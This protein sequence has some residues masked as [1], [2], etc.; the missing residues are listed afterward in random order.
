[1]DEEGA[2]RICKYILKDVYESNSLALV[3]EIVILSED[4]AEFMYNRKLATHSYCCDVVAIAGS[5]KQGLQYVIEILYQVG[6]DSNIV[7]TFPKL[8]ENVKVHWQDVK[9]MHGIMKLILQVMERC[10]VET[11]D[12]IVKKKI[13]S[14]ISVMSSLLFSTIPFSMELNIK[15]DFPRCA[16]EF[17]DYCLASLL[18][19]TVY[20]S[21]SE[22]NAN[23]E[24]SKIIRPIIPIISFVLDLISGHYM[25]LIEDDDVQKIMRFS[26]GI[27]TIFSNHT[28]EKRGPSTNLTRGKDL[29][30]LISSKVL[31]RLITLF[32]KFFPEKCCNA[33]E[34]GP[35]TLK[36]CIL[37]NGIVSFL[38]FPGLAKTWKGLSNEE[39]IELVKILKR[40]LDMEWIF[41]SEGLDLMHGD[42]CM[43]IIA[44]I[45]D[46][47]THQDFL[48]LF[49]DSEN[50]M[51]STLTKF[52]KRHPS[53]LNFVCL[54]L[55]RILDEYEVDDL[56]DHLLTV[57][58]MC[59][60][61]LLTHHELT[62]RKGIKL[63]SESKLTHLTTDDQVREYIP[64]MPFRVFEVIITSISLVQLQKIESKSSIVALM[65]RLLK[66]S[67]NS[68]LVVALLVIFKYFIVQYQLSFLSRENLLKII[69]VVWKKPK[70]LKDC[71]DVE[72]S[73]VS[74]TY[75]MSLLMPSCCDL[76]YFDFLPLLLDE[77][78]HIHLFTPLNPGMLRLLWELAKRPE[79]KQLVKKLSQLSTDKIIDYASPGN[80]EIAKVYKFISDFIIEYLENDPPFNVK[81]L[82]D[83]TQCMVGI[84]A[85]SNLDEELYV[86]E[87]MVSPAIWL[88]EKQSDDNLVAN[89]KEFIRILH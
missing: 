70:M 12:L 79:H 47:G 3:A 51:I 49:S 35:C 39:I 46:L 25:V 77:L 53:S 81:Y 4:L 30:L 76:C 41:A 61:H 83:L 1:M 68:A 52:A 22:C 33:D 32:E 8:L 29:K 27:M 54:V 62:D 23:S 48:E 82:T 88:L 71:S 26:I 65:L 43:T 45:I 55:W 2:D 87:D 85:Y 16:T 37:L 73:V 58:S 57:P 74:F 63:F 31:E 56:S 59:L 86:L 20:T 24:C 80:T 13:M 78:Q 28:K 66:K 9:L 50:C 14:T 36:D 7:K 75:R 15:L 38:Q 44:E 64:I 40:I 21:V 72:A 6:E 10:E 18:I 89:V 19:D 60:K 34:S 42:V 5:S 67:K 17:S 69:P 11:I 84:A